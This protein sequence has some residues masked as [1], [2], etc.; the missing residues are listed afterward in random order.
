MTHAVDNA[1]DVLALTQAQ[2]D[3]VSAAI[4]LEQQPVS[5]LVADRP[6]IEGGPD[7]EPGAVKLR[8]FT[9]PK[10]ERLTAYRYHRHGTLNEHLFHGWPGEDY[11][12]PVLTTVIFERRGGIIIG[13]DLIPSPDVIFDRTY[14]GRH[15][16]L[17]AYQ[18]LLADYWPRLT[19]FRLGPEPAPNAYFTKQV[20][21]PLMV[22]EY[23]EEEAIDVAK[24]LVLDVT[25]LWTELHAAAEKAPEA[26]RARTNE[27]RNTL[28]LKS[29]KGLDY[30]SPASDGLCA[31]LGWEATN[32]MFDNVFGPDEVPQV[33]DARRRYLDMDVSPGTPPRSK[34]ETLD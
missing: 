5:P 3:I 28:R 27:R 19:K 30:H 2:L 32:L 17:L 31:V 8:T 7:N 26:D 20:G 1:E 6:W 9:G 16:L 25:K 14:Y 12:Y 10:I 4:P 23:L 21:S 29:Y 11:D 18:D 34:S 15:N 24:D 13:T 33:A 22:L